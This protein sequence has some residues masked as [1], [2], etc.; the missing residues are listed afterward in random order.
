V[1]K[2]KDVEALAASSLTVPTVA[3]TLGVRCT[4]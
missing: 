3:R 1:S 4:L 2:R